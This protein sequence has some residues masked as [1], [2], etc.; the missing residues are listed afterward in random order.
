MAILNTFPQFFPDASG[1]PSPLLAIRALLVPT[2]AYDGERIVGLTQALQR[3]QKKSRSFYLAS[4]TFEGPLRTNLILLYSFC[5]VADDL[6]DD[7]ASVTESRD[8]IRKLRTFLILSFST[9]NTP[10]DEAKLRSFVMSNFPTN[11]QLALMQLPTHLLTI[12]PLN[13]LLDGF[14]MDLSF[15]TEESTR[16]KWPIDSVDDLDRYGF[17]VAGTVAQLCLDLV[18]NLYSINK[19]VGGNLKDAGGL[20]GI[21]LQIVNI[22]RDIEVDT[23]MGRVYIPKRWL[24]ENDMTPEDVLKNPS[25]AKV[26]EL[27]SQLLDK[28]FGYYEEAKL[29]LDQLPD[30]VRGPMRVAVESYMEIGRTL[31]LKHYE[32]KAGRATV[33]RIQRLRVAWRALNT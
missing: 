32:V 20:M 2:S 23:A 21:A 27:R 19:T 12:K 25:G 11:A 31:R 17:C 30:E 22:A 4:S 3:L 24:K 5:R 29:A 18:I 7:S 6:V 9:T 14:D 8:W 13:G 15:M 16:K 1:R 26:K 28:G 10:R 33:P